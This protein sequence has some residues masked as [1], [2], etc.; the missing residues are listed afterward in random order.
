MENLAATV[1]SFHYEKSGFGAV[2][3]CE[4]SEILSWKNINRN[5]HQSQIVLR[6]YDSLL[7]DRVDSWT[8]AGRQERQTFQYND[9]NGTEWLV[10]YVPFFPSQRFGSDVSYN[11]L[12]LL[13][14][15][16]VDEADAPRSSSVVSF[17]VSEARERVFSDDL[18]DKLGLV[19]PFDVEDAVE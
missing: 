15:A 2:I 16:R 7:A 3:N 17:E 13:M 5:V 11:A 10:S 19:Q 9:V 18:D 6:D 14:F 12:A 4:T 1:N 8:Y